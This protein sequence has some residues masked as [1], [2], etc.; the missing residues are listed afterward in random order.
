MSERLR[1]EEVIRIKRKLGVALLRTD[2]LAEGV[3]VLEEALGRHGI[4]RG[5]MARVARLL[6]DLA[7][8]LWGRLLRRSPKFDL[9]LKERA[10]AHHELAII[11]RW[12]DMGKSAS[13][14][15]AFIRAAYR[16]G[17]PSLLVDA[18]VSLSFLFT[19]QA[20]PRAA[21]RHHRRAVALSRSAGNVEAQVRAELVRGG[22]LVLIEDDLTLG[23]RH[24]DEGVRLA[25]AHGDRFLINL[26]LSLRGLGHAIVGR[27]DRAR[28][29]HRGAR[30]LADELNVPWLRLDSDCGL[31]MVELFFGNH[32]AGT[33]AAKG[34]LT[35]GLRLAL[36]ALEAQANEIMG[37][38]A[39][40]DGRFREAVGYLDR[41]DSHLKTHRL[42]RAWGSM[43]KLVRLEAR[44]CLADEQSM[45]TVPDLLPML[46]E[47]RRVWQ[48]MSSLP[49]YRGCD[50]MVAG[51]YDSRR[52]H[53]RMARQRF[54][55][56]RTQRVQAPRTIHIDGW[57]RSRIAFELSRLGT[58]T[59]EVTAEL[60]DVAESYRKRELEGACRWLANMRAVYGV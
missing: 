18:H 4:P 40:L 25:R 50:T 13:H 42:E 15:A 58:P 55:E 54:A 29:D 19:M 5:R 2:E 48:H 46:R 23:E 17:V 30:A 22:S 11:H 10:I 12:I 28:E 27:L 53:S 36:P 33:R 1:P 45:K 26:A 57:C 9:E 38:E 24:L 39:A 51:I 41:V 34:V 14:L 35:S 21:S 31:G 7:G 32:E 16:V 44:L 43:T 47:S 37:I 56:A 6:G 60:D 49:I 59:A 3:A 8:F 52:G 20:W